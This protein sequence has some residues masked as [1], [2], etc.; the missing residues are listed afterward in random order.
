[1]AL[2]WAAGMHGEPWTLIGSKGR[3]CYLV[4]CRVAALPHC[5]ARTVLPPAPR[6]AGRGAGST[7]GTRGDP[8]LHNGLH[9]PL[10]FAS[11]LAP[12]GRKHGMA[13]H[14]PPRVLLLLA[15]CDSR[16]GEGNIFHTRLPSSVNALACPS[17]SVTR[18]QRLDPSC[19]VL[20][21]SV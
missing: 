20:I 12:R 15:E 10:T 5:C 14:H 8:L 19:L 4:G 21:N 2:L 18:L 13:W 11:C 7:R 17:D 9:S 16:W 3:G 1:M 6:G